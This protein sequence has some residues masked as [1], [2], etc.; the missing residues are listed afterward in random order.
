MYLTIT[1]LPDLMFI[2][3]RLSTY[4][5]NLTEQ[6]SFAAKKVLRYIQ[7]TCEVGI[8]YKKGG[9]ET[10][11][12]YTKSD[13]ARDLDYMKNTFKYIFL[14][15]SGAISWSPKKQPVMTFS[16]TEG[17]YIV[18]VSCACQAIWLN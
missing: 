9:D 6:H 2:V 18:A 15:N 11:I 4:M 10:L 16:T 12:A 14:L 1:T 5:E 7:E 8:L 17:E 13:Y 3:R